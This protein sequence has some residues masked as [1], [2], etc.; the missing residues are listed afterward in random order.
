MTT[1]GRTTT[2]TRAKIVLTGV[3]WLIG[4]RRSRLL[5]DRGEAIARRRRCLRVRLWRLDLEAGE[6]GRSLLRSRDAAPLSVGC[7]RGTGSKTAFKGP[8]LRTLLLVE[9]RMNAGV[10]GAITCGSWRKQWNALEL[11]PGDKVKFSAV[12]KRYTKGISW[13]ARR[14][15]SPAS[16][17]GL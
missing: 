17:G 14:L 12:V 8:P 13:A 9:I 3:D 2:G 6:C 15:R 5:G 16:D 7:S 4:G 1:S 11:E 10:L